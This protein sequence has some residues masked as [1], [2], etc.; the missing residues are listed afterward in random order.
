MENRPR[1]VVLDGQTMNPGDLSWGPLSGLGDLQAYPETKPDEVIPR[2]EGAVAALTNK[3]V[4]D[5][6]HFSRLP[7]LRLVCL[8]ATGYDVVDI[9]AAD[10]RGIVVCNVRDYATHSVAQHVFALLLALTNRVSEHDQDVRRG[11]WERSRRWS[12]TTREIVALEGRVMGVVGLGRIGRQV[13]LLAQAFGMEVQAYHRHPERDGLPGVHFVG[14][15]ELLASSD[16]VSLHVPLTAETRHLI[17]RERLAGMRRGS[18]LINTGRGGLVDEPALRDALEQ[19]LVAGAGLDVLSVEP[20]AGGNPLIGA[21]NCLVTPHHAWATVT[22]RQRLLQG[23][24]D[25]V[26]AFLNGTPANVVGRVGRP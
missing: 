5:D 3:V 15:E 19:G 12:L 21:R 16:V 1:I 2:L 26:A 8:M 11:E 17:N 9:P 18:Y 10:R 22:A 20:P 14:L 4:L 6:R 23:C 7:D 25:N 24:A 13:A